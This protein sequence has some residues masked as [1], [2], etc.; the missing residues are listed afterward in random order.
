V[1]IL[2]DLGV[3]SAPLLAR[4]TGRPDALLP[5][6]ARPLARLTAADPNARA[7]PA[8]ALGGGGEALDRTRTLEFESNAW[9]DWRARGLGGNHGAVPGVWRPI[10]QRELTRWY[11]VACAFGAV[12]IATDRGAVLDTALY[13]PVPDS[14][15]P[16]VYRLRRALGRLYAVPLVAAPGRDAD[17][18][19][20]MGSRDFVPDVI[21]FA[22]EQDRDVAGEYPGSTRCALRWVR[23]D[24]DR[25]EIEARAPAPAFVVV[26]DTWF[27]GWHAHIDGVPARIHRVNQALRGV[28]VP[29]GV[30]R[31]AMDYEPE[32]WRAGVAWT[33]AAAVAWLALAAALALVAWRA[34]RGARN[35]SVAAPPSP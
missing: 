24:P 12:Y 29:A 13:T 6:P 20:A 8:R 1:A 31:I 35:A 17:V 15:D 9:I 32:G 27:P 18:V 23:D 4:A 10:V 11:P 16:P 2:L 28:I 19:D 25:L 5:P 33:R 3:V 21:A 34:R 7:F 22:S 14:G 26:A 30:H